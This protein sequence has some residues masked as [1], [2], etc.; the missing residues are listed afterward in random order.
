MVDYYVKTRRE[1]GEFKDSIAITARALEALARLAEASARIRLSEEATLQ[2]ARRAIRLTQNWRHDLMGDSFD[3]TTMA[4]GK[5]G[6]TRNRER[7]ILDIV[8]RMCREM[9][10][11]VDLT[12]VLNEAERSDINRT[13]A[14]DIID[15][16]V[17]AGR[18]FR[19]SYDTLNLT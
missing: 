13:I 1:G 11:N 5:K 19:P 6:S 10:A 3:E 14:E 12:I 18:M 4:S 7:I 2:D 9:D 15:D 16:H 17:T 8:E